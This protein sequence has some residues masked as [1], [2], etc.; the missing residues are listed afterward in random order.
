MRNGEKI[1]AIPRRFRAGRANGVRARTRLHG[2]LQTINQ[3]QPGGKYELDA[4]SCIEFSFYSLDR[5]DGEEGRGG[6]LEQTVQHSIPVECGFTTLNTICLLHAIVPILLTAPRSDVPRLYVRAHTNRIV[7]RFDGIRRESK[8]SADRV[9]P[10]LYVCARVS[11]VARTG[12]ST[13]PC[14]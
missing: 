2:D 7:F 1:E 12:F 13:V 9:K 8:E 11:R 5:G 14:E 4:L 3:F 6:R 10:T